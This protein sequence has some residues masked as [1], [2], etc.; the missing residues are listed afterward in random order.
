MRT[1]RAGL[2]LSL[3]AAILI[4]VFFIAPLAILLPAAMCEFDVRMQPTWVGLANVRALLD[5]PT[6][7]KA[8]GVTLRLALATFASVM[9]TAL[10]GGMILHSVNAGARLRVLFQL[11]S[12][13]GTAANSVFWAWLFA[14]M[15]G[16]LAQLSRA[17]G[18]TPIMWH[19][20]AV[21][22]QIA[23]CVVLFAWLFPG[24]TYFVAVA[25]SGVPKDLLEAAQ[26]D[27]ANAWQRFWHVTMPVMRRPLTYVAVTFL[28]G[29]AQVYEVPL[30]L[31]QGGPLGG[32][33]TVMM[34][35]AR[36]DGGYGQA[37]ALA[38][39]LTVVVSGLC[40]VAWKIGER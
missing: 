32:T 21:S 34:S 31:W 20:Q 35:I 23:C 29:V 3:P 25:A 16:G 22:A 18:N 2:L 14:P 28:A 9:T 7:A 12:M 10:V 26:I 40:Y 1:S 11:C 30:L 39:L 19:A 38:L 17:M 13:L 24:N 33:T 4:C 6:V 36:V 27:G 8:V 15:W 37:A 5:S